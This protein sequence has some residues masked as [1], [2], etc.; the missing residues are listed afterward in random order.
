MEVKEFETE[1]IDVI[2]RAPNVKS[3]RFSIP[4]DTEIDFKAGQFFVVT[5]KI[6]GEDAFK[7]F[8]FSNSP[9]EKEYIEFTKR[10]T[11]SVFS[12]AL[13]RLKKGD[14]AKLKLPF[15]FFTF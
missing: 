14:W 9:Y 7:H 1:V 3:F 12:Q 4:E 8:S 11:E 10:I 5:I 15:G 2:R 6:N 13:D